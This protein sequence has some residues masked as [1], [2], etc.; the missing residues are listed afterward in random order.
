M[1]DVKSVSVRL[2]FEVSEEEAQRLD[3][4]RALCGL[5]TKKD[6]FNNALTILEWA[7]RQRQSGRTI[8]SI[9]PNREQCELEMPALES[10]ASRPRNGAF[11]D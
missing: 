3:D 7:V 10:A 4:L 1:A 11:D 9:G 8:N 6:L 2:Q 5:R